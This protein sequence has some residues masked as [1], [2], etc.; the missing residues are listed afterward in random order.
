MDGILNERHFLR[1]AAVLPRY[2]LDRT[3]LSETKLTEQLAAVVV[4]SQ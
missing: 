4:A 2:L 1:D 3:F